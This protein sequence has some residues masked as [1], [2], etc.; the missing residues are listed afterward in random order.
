MPHY[1]VPVPS[2]LIREKNLDK[3]IK[4]AKVKARREAAR[5][6]S[7]LADKVS[8][9]DLAVLEEE[10]FKA[11]G[12]VADG[13]AMRRLAAAQQGEAVLADGV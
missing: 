1:C 7:E 4:E 10:F 8:D 6:D 13:I 9:Q 5:K 3:A 2:V 11:T 12:V